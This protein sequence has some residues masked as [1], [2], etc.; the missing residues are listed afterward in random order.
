MPELL[1]SVTNESLTAVIQGLELKPD[2]VVYAIGGSGDQAF[3][4]LEY[5]KRVIV[6]DSNPEQ[7]K[8]I[9]R[10]AE[11]LEKSD[12]AKFLSADEEGKNDKIFGGEN[13]PLLA[14]L[15]KNRRKA[16]FAR[17]ETKLGVN[18]IWYNRLDHIKNKLDGLKI[19]E[20]DFFQQ[21]STAKDYSKV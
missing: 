11:M 3:A 14:V 15:N 9:K 6:I 13:I 5:A 17:Y 2:D 12:Y 21:I 16:Y 8:L 7:I 1:Y 4:I 20:G 10:R 18:Y 19:V